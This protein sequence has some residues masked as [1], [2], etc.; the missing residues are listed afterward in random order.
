MKIMKFDL[1]VAV[2]ICCVAI[3][4][5][6]GAKSVPL[7]TIGNIHLSASVALLVVPLIYTIND[8]IVEVFGRERARSVVLCGLIVVGLLLLMSLLATSLPPTPRFAGHETAY[9]TIFRQS[10]RI[11]G[12]S[13]TAFALAELLD[14]WVFSKLR[15]KM[16]SQALWLR[17]NVSNFAAQFVDTIVFMTLA[18][19]AVDKSLASNIGFL[20]GLII[21]YWL[22][23]CM[24]SMIETP[25]VYGGVRWLRGTNQEKI[26]EISASY[27]LQN[28]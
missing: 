14:V 27:S 5:L 7:F 9:D 16:G 3:S 18:F 6:M 24:M 1:L 26:G 23:K 15:E 2:Y 11:A 4:E 19:Y 22:L 20:A 17:N 8:V 28:R 13:L 21:P 25:F 10:A 12:A